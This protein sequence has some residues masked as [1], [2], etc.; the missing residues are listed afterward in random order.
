MKPVWAVS[1]HRR[2]GRNLVGL[3]LIVNIVNQ[4]GCQGLNWPP[5]NAQDAKQDLRSTDIPVRLDHRHSNRADTNVN[6]PGFRV[7]RG[8]TLNY[9][10]TALTR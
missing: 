6:A 10:L 3:E 4:A 8:S 2:H 5:K 9:S 7:F 1:Q